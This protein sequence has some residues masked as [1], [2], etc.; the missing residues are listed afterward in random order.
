MD[1][2]LSTGPQSAHAGHGKPEG[3][4]R[5]EALR[6]AIC[7]RRLGQT[8]AY[9]EETGEVPEPRQSW[10]LCAAC[11]AAVHEQM[12]QS[13]VR[14]PLRLRVAVG[15]V[16]AERTPEA[17]REGFGQL[18]DQAWERF[19]FWSFVLAFMAHLAVLVFVAALI[20]HH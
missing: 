2:G 18:S 9:V 7:A 16:A 19:F 12:E 4:A 11:N 8:L 17:R 1:Q 14:S 15:L 3:A 13:P 6:C 20:A 10:L 5:G